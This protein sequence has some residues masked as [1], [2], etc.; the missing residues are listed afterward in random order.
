ML[1]GHPSWI[2]RLGEHCCDRITAVRWK[3]RRA[4]MADRTAATVLCALV[5]ERVRPW[6]ATSNYGRPRQ[7]QRGRGPF[8]QRAAWQYLPIEIR[9]ATRLVTRKVERSIHACGCWPYRCR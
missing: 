2:S 1:A 4:H 6:H 5:Q 9:I 7:D 3:S 8:G